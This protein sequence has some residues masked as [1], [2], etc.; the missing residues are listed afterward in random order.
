MANNGYTDEHNPRTPRYPDIHVELTD[1]NSF[2]ILGLIGKRLR[3]DGIDPA[4]FYAEALAGN[5]DH[6]LLTAMR[7]VDVI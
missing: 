1:G 3:A 6:M 4:E 5:R 2:A 7:T